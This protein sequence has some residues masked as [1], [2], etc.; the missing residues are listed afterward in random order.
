MPRNYVRKKMPS[1][2]KAA[3]VAALEDVEKNKKSILAA[4]KE[5][6]IPETTL[7]RFRN[8]SNKLVNFHQ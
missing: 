4:S 3:V 7:R 1:Y 6:N 2:D 5:Y 8:M